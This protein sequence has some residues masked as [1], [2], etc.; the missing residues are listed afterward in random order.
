MD[1][2]KLNIQNIELNYLPGCKFD[3][4]EE[5]S[6]GTLEVHTFEKKY[7]LYTHQNDQKIYIYNTLNGNVYLYK[8]PSALP[9]LLNC[10]ASNEIKGMSGFAIVN[11]QYCF[12][13]GDRRKLY[14]FD[15]EFNDAG[16]INTN[17]ESDTMF[18][19]QDKMYLYN[20][21]KALLAEFTLQDGVL[22]PGKVTEIKGIGN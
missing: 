5:F 17:F 18:L 11:D 12:Y 19:H 14:F 22:T 7:Y 8:N 2:N 10:Y 20:R 9:E 21:K 13:H 16:Q 1:K 4:V 6:D 15:M 3:T